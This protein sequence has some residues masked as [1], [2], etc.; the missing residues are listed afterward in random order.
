MLSTL[1][2]F[3]GRITRAE[4]WV[5]FLTWG[6]V[7]A[8][9]GRLAETA[10]SF[11]CRWL[12]VVYVSVALAAMV[13]FQTLTCRRCHDLGYGS[14][15]WIRRP[16]AVAFRRGMDGPNTYGPAPSR[17][18]VWLLFAALILVA[19]SCIVGVRFALDRSIATYCAL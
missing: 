16:F 19:S 8:A 7:L 5:N 14:L 18:R 12:L 6:I 10:F 2:S 11:G 17:T 3:R 15:G 13:S 4:L 1:F 9:V